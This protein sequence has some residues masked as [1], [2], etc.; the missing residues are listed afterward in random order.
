MD[1]GRVRGKHHRGG[2]VGDSAR[3][4]GG[5]E[6]EHVR[7]FLGVPVLWSREKRVSRFANLGE[8]GRAHV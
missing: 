1:G 8:I 4:A 3:P 6:G 7:K 2:W 5:P